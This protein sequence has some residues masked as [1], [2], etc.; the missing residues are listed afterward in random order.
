MQL[1]TSTSD[2]KFIESTF[3]HILSVKAEHLDVDFFNFIKDLCLHYCHLCT[4]EGAEGLVSRR[5]DMIKLNIYRLLEQL[6]SW[7][8]EN[9][10]LKLECL[11]AFAAIAK[12]YPFAVNMDKL[13]ENI[14]NRFKSSA[15]DTV[16]VGAIR[17]LLSKSFPS[18]LVPLTTPGLD[19]KRFLAR[20]SEKQI[21]LMEL[22]VCALESNE[23]VNSLAIFGELV[24]LA[25]S[26]ITD[27]NCTISLIQI[28]R[29]YTAYLVSEA[30]DG[31]CVLLFELIRTEPSNGEQVVE[32]LFTDFWPRLNSETMSVR[33]FDLV[34]EVF[35]RKN[36]YVDAAYFDNEQLLYQSNVHGK[37]ALISLCLFSKNDHVVDSSMDLFARCH[38]DVPLANTI[39]SAKDFKDM[40]LKIM[41]TTRKDLGIFNRAVRLLSK[42]DQLF[43]ERH[44]LFRMDRLRFRM[45]SGVTLKIKKLIVSPFFCFDH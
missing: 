33:C 10:T 18:L 14:V 7:A 41:R 9:P 36:F 4:R 3:N 37:E 40:F 32:L 45:N 11:D 2:T 31:V 6:L 25:M 15:N 23:A 19:G 34:T 27:L 5:I 20:L 30:F 8:N 1:C 28:K 44:E 12:I 39:K 26:L 24:S 13:F 42:F 43:L 16:N 22:V 35:R 17:M 38:L 29:I 21:D